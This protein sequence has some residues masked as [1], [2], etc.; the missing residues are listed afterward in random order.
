M[1]QKCEKVENCR[2]HI[3]IWS[4]NSAE[5]SGLEAKKRK[6][7]YIQQIQAEQKMRKSR[8]LDQHVLHLR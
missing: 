2:G 6:K 3:F 8:Q 7:T 1:S 4:G 5:L